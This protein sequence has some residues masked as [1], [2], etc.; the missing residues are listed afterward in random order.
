MVGRRHAGRGL[1]HEIARRLAEVGIDNPAVADRYPFQLSGGMSQRVAIAAS[2]AGDPH[3]LIADE[4][5][6]A[7]D[8]TTQ[9]DVI[10]LL[11]SIQ[12]ARRMSLILITHD[13]RLA[14]SAC[15]RIMVMY[16][17][18]IVETAP[19]RDLDRS[20]RCI[21]TRATSCVP[22]PRR[23]L[24]AHAARHPRGDPC[25]QCRADQCGVRRT[26]R[27]RRRAAAPVRSRR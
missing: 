26:L 18:S 7:L 6:T 11:L 16:A 19:S 20:R 8:T 13:L 22:C 1:E 21:R 12:R 4:P 27:V 25:G 17:G 3:L 23:R 24:P 14:F 5:T 9:R 2:L 10:E 15:D